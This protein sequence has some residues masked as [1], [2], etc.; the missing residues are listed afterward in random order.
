MCPA[1]IARSPNAEA[2]CFRAFST[3]TRASVTGVVD[4]LAGTPG[5]LLMEI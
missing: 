4:V 3:A 1:A 5:V 2:N